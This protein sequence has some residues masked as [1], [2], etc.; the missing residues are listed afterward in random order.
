MGEGGVGGSGVSFLLTVVDNQ[1]GERM[2]KPG[3]VNSLNELCGREVFVQTTSRAS[4]RGEM[5]G[6]LDGVLTLHIGDQIG[7]QAVAVCL[8]LAN[9]ESVH[10]AEAASQGSLAVRES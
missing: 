10:D 7:D 6:V 1:K 4:W 2:T 9:V 3:R 8:P 5:V